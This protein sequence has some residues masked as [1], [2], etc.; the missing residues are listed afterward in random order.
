VF[1]PG[2]NFRARL[3]RAGL[4]TKN[5][6][7][8]AGVFLCVV[9]NEVSDK[10]LILVMK[11][12]LIVLL[13]T[14]FSWNIS[15]EEAPLAK[16]E[17]DIQ[18]IRKHF[19][20]SSDDKTLKSVDILTQ[21]TVQSL[22]KTLSNENHSEEKQKAFELWSYLE[23]ALHGTTAQMG[24]LLSNNNYDKND[25]LRQQTDLRFETINNFYQEALRA[26][27]Q[28]G[29]T[30]ILELNFSKNGYISAISVKQADPGMINLAE[31]ITPAMRTLRIPAQTSPEAIDY[32]L[33][34]FPD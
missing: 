25:A 6:G 21:Q 10:K 31:R 28:L 14:L 7:L 22:A 26:H 19:H 24:G 33:E 12:S 2:A 16:I 27:P 4:E 15:A 23:L 13:T 5:P 34:F 3:T 29:G 1:R 18:L 17:Q 30:I 32:K 11:R 20:S 8:S 9:Y